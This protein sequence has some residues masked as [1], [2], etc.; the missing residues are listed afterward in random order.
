[1]VNAKTYLEVNPAVK[2][3]ILDAAQSV[4]GVWAEERLYPGLKTNNM[5]G[6][7]EFSGFPMTEGRFGVKAGQHI[8]GRVVHEYLHQYAQ[9]FGL[10]PVI[11]LRCKVQTAEMRQTGQWELTTLSR[12]ADDP[13]PKIGRILADKLIVARD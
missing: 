11:R 3:I 13:P 6:T 10:L 8:T 4:G 5:L 1:M 7:Y 12:D 9:E 2:V